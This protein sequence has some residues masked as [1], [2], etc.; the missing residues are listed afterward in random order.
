MIWIADFLPDAAAGA[1]GAMMDEG[2][3]VMKETLDR[4]ADARIPE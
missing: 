2:M 3:K 1:I 4:L